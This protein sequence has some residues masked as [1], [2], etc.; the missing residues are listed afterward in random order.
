[1]SSETLRMLEEEGFRW[2]ASGQQVLH[3]S[4]SA[5]SGGAS[6]PEDWLH[7]SYRL[8]EGRLN[9][10]FRDDG[11]SDLIGFTYADWHA[12]DAV[13]NLVQHL[14][15]IAAV[16]AGGGERTVSVI[17]DGENAWEYYPK[18]GCYF[19]TALYQRL[20]EHPHLEMTTFSEILDGRKG[21]SATLTELVAGSWVYGT[22]STWIGD[23][24]KNRAWDMLVEAKQCYDR[25]M[26]S[27]VLDSEKRE[28]AELQLA[29]C[30]GS[31]WFWWFGDYNPGET[32]S[33]F[34]RLFRRQL[35]HLYQLLGE[36]PPE[37]LSKVFAHG[38]GD[39][40]MGGVM[41]QNV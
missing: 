21:A 29:R 17:M 13:G 41:R 3:N 20:A 5:F 23:P 32:V 24:D 14:E 9:C 2:A 39:P 27:D 19:L 8:G 40:E 18:N 22:F 33:D 15:N 7:Q 10:F 26:A 28:Q 1:M 11:L 25:V 6:L 4:L 12:D 35:T 37:Y 16:D 34:E 31:D 38:S 30:E 36:A